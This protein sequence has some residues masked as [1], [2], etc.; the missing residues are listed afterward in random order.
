[1]MWLAFLINLT[2]YPASSGLLPYVAK[3]VYHVDATGLGWLV[4]S[5][6]FGGLLASITMVLTGGPRHPER[7]T[8]VHTAS[9]TGCCSPSATRRSLGVGLLTLLLAGFVAERGDDLDD[10]DAAR[11]RGRPASGD[12]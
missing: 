8:L 3:R 12:G 10:R 11:R 5:F 1:M 2:A 7:S 6:S 9:G 4:A